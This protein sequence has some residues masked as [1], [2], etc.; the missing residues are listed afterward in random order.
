M[1]WLQNMNTVWLTKQPMD[2]EPG[3]LDCTASSA[4]QQAAS[5]SIP[6]FFHL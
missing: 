1:L 4:M 5:L 2:L 6:V 3:E